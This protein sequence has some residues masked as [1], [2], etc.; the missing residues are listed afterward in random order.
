MKK[1]FGWLLILLVFAVMA[2]KIYL[3][4]FVQPVKVAEPMEINETLVPVS[5]TASATTKDGDLGVSTF[6]APKVEQDAWVTAQFWQNASAQEVRQK[7][8][9]GASVLERNSYGVSILMYAASISPNPDVIDV[10]VDAGAVMSARDEKGQTALMYAASFNANPEVVQRLIERGAKV[11][12]SDKRGWSS[13]MHAASR[14]QNAEIIDVLIE[15]GADVNERVKDDRPIDHASLPQRMVMSLKTSLNV[16]QEFV[17]SLASVR[18]KE[19]VIK[20]FD[21]SIDKLANDVL[22]PEEDMT[23]LMIAARDSTSPQVLRAL[24][25]GGAKVKLYD[26]K[27]QTAVDYAKSNAAIGNTDIYWEMN[28]LLY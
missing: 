12:V 24:L 9:E 13:L 4:F 25:R 26:T 14:N 15:N 27:G 5:A 11:N 22:N 8:Y 1:F 2:F 18:S 3:H 10:L 19:D 7:I 20:V 16:T 23:P 6:S 17:G 21:K 28:D